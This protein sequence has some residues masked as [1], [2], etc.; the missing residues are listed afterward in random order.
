MTIREAINRA[1]STKANQYSDEM[2]MQW[3]SELDNRIYNDLF[4]THEDNPYADIEPP[5]EGEE[6]ERLIFPYTDDS[7][8]L[9]AESPYDVL[10][11]SYIKAKIDETNEEFGKY[12]N[13]SAIYNSQY[14]DYARWYNRSHMPITRYPK[15]KMICTCQDSPI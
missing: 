7:K 3:L 12:L 10:Y 15:G 14:Q 4:L 8:E 5:E 6:D 9:L 13:S 11:P 1:D 2:K